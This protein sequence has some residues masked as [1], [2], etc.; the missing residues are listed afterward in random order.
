MRLPL[1][2][3]VGRLPT[4][5]TSRTM[6]C[7]AMGAASSV[8]GN[9]SLQWVERKR[10]LN[11][12]QPVGAES[13]QACARARSGALLASICLAGVA[14]VYSHATW[15]SAS[16]T[17]YCVEGT[18]THQTGCFA[19]LALAE[20]FMSTNTP[21]YSGMLERSGAVPMG[22]D[23][24]RLNYLVRD[25]SAKIM[26]SMLYSIGGWRDMRAYC[27]TGVAGGDPYFPYMCPSE[28]DVIDGW[29]AEQLQD[30]PSC[31]YT[32][33]RVSGSYLPK[34]TGIHGN[35]PGPNGYL[36]IVGGDD[37]RRKLEWVISCDGWSQAQRRWVEISRV[38]SFECPEDFR[39]VDAVQGTVPTPSICQAW[40]QTPYILVTD[41]GSIG[42]CSDS[43]G[44]QIGD[45]SRTLLN[46][47]HL[48]RL[49]TL[50]GSQDR[51]TQSL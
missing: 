49:Q 5:M 16:R 17:T 21:S 24:T 43:C 46:L 7:A 47:P 14:S 33:I 10:P 36:W 38:Q 50:T 8:P 9:V 13:A 27:P 44:I 22:A 25:R 32:N 40:R 28:Q 42:P 1:S 31:R 19:T 29:I 3:K 6:T 30:S 41:R 2:R 20:A 11:T 15:A 4:S 45:L 51:P 18:H 48:R 37:A 23:V 39:A 26:R 35:W 34:D 12:Q